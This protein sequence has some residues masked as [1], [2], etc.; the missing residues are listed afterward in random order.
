MPFCLQP[1]QTFILLVIK[2]YMPEGCEGLTVS[3][4]GPVAMASCFWAWLL[5]T[6]CS[7]SKNNNVLRF[8]GMLKISF[9]QYAAL[10]WASWGQVADIGHYSLKGSCSAYIWTK[11]S[12]NPPKQTE[13][14]LLNWKMNH[15]AETNQSLVLIFQMFSLR[16]CPQNNAGDESCLLWRKTDCAPVPSHIRRKYER[17][18]T[19]SATCLHLA[20]Q[21]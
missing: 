14:K 21:K 7:A 2:A 19:F 1:V 3:R 12:N 9:Q 17:I 8:E 18:P 20:T 6:E 16:N 4:D 13:N 11:R 10:G 15:Y 5:G